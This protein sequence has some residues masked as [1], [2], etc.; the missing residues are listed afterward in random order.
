MERLLITGGLGHIGSKLIHSIGPGQFDEILIVDNLSTMRYSSFFNLPQGVNFKLYDEDILEID[1]YKL[2]ESIDVV[3]HLAAITDATNSFHKKDQIK[4]VN[5]LGTKRLAEACIAKNVKLIFP[6]TTSVYGQQSEIVDEKCDGSNLNPQSPYA[7][8]KLK[9][10][11]L[12]INMGDSHNLKFI[13]CRFGTIFGQSIG[14]RFHT[15]VNKFCWQAAMGHPLT[16]WETAFNQK[17]PYLGVNDAINAIK[18]I[19]NQDLFD[20]QIYNVVS[21]NHT[22]REIVEL[23]KEIIPDLKI[24]FINTEIMNQLSYEVDS[25]KIRAC[26]FIARDDID[27]GIKETINQLL[28]R[29]APQ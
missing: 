8:Y 1:F 5:Y 10:E 20:N 19:I 22:V 6:S 16:V 25:N 28:N 27:I 11:K 3:I 23:I 14:M 2:L 7:Y 26:G 21:S 9:S 29:S 12:L 17:R 24:N 15:A 18:F 13:I 4:L